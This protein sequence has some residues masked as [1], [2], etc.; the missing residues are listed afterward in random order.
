[1]GQGAAFCAC[2][3][4]QIGEAGVGLGIVRSQRQD[5]LPSPDG[6]TILLQSFMLLSR[7]APGRG[8]C[9]SGLAQP[10]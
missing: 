8:V 1:M 2:L 4:E 7:Q 6:L 5:G 9:V 10:L 3:K